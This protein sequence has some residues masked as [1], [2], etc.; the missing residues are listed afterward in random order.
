[1]V[2]CHEEQQMDIDDDFRLI[3]GLKNI[4]PHQR[5]TIEH[6]LNGESVVLRAP[7]GSGKSEAV[8]V[9]FLTNINKTLP[10]QLIYSLPVRVLVDDLSR[11]FAKYSNVKGVNVA[12]HHGKRI[13]TPLF[14]PPIIITTIDQTVGAYVCT[15]LSLPLRAGNI[16]AGAVSSAFL[17]FDEV[18]TFD[19]ERALQSALILA[20]HSSKLNLPFVFMSA[21]MPD[22]FLEKLGEIFDFKRV[23][24]NEKDILIRKNRKVHVYWE[25]KDKTLAGEDVIENYNKSKGKLIVICNTV[26]KA[27][28]IYKEVENEVGCETVLLHSRFL[29]ED[30]KRKEEKLKDIFGK[31]SN[32][33]GILISTQVIE[34]GLDISCDT[35]LTELSPIDSLIQRAGRCSRWGG[36]GFLHVYDVEKPSPYKVDIMK[37][38]RAE[39]EKF[40]G[41]LF[42]WET[43]KLLVN[44]V[45]GKYVEKW[46]KTENMA[47]IL[48]TLSQ[49]AFEGNKRLAEDAVRSIFSCDISIHDAPDTLENVYCLKTINVHV[50]VLRKFFNDDNPTMWELVDNN[51]ISDDSSSIIPQRIYD[52]ESILPYHFYIVH[53][54]CISYDENR[55]LLFEPGG[56]NFG[57]MEKEE[58]K[59]VEYDCKRET[60][61]EHSKRTVDAFNHILLPRYKFAIERFASALKVEYDEFLERLQVSMLLHDIGKLNEGWQAK[62]G[63]DGKEPLAHSDV[64]VGRLPSHAPISAYALSSV[65]YEWNPEFG[66]AF[67]FALAHH[68][69]VRASKMPKYKLID[70][71][72]NCL[73]Q[74]SVPDAYIDK[75][76]A[77]GEGGKLSGTFPELSNHVKLYR[78]YT[79]VSRL[80]RISDRIATGGG[81]DAILRY[82]NWYGNV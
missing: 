53:P 31:N 42:D 50:G 67:Y 1:M 39:I 63:W 30:R 7:T 26:S 4:Y 62:I 25:G 61:V 2:R 13:E 76:K 70:G 73:R 59:I 11:R 24:A 29:E 40:E 56:N 51:I 44:I 69:S 41:E 43:E 68:H 74:L 80:L 72:E 34:V 15:P 16:P 5:E 9:P 12:G 19:P 23:D 18:H 38:T 64:Y 17:V 49:A 58:E 81:E 27:Q 10:S 78:T 79:F 35:M 66:Q 21:T 36:S 14:Y 75:I 3:T 71:W 82:E 77:D 37:D 22:V 20:K 55:G 6:I 46:L 54:D 8:I 28:D 57:F 32:K 65:F 47:R 45:L 52:V 60:W 33:K 48:S